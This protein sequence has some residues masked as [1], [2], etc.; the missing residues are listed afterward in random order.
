MDE[1]KEPDTVSG[2]VTPSG[3]A[4]NNTPAQN[5]AS[6][7]EDQVAALQALI[8]TNISD[9]IAKYAPGKTLPPRNRQ[10]ETL[11]SHP[12]L[13]PSSPHALFVNPHKPVLDRKVV[14]PVTR[15]LSRLDPTLV[16]LILHLPHRIDKTSP[17]VNVTPLLETR[18]PKH[19][20]R[21]GI[22]PTVGR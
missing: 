19:S 2:R 6:F 9:A 1:H 15:S 22:S 11:A 16:I 4:D 8:S 7:S 18:K 17:K 14:G 13:L 3:M 21:I 10:P 5:P 12:R 20:R